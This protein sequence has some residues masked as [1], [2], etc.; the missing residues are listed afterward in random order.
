MPWISKR[1][2]KGWEFV[3]GLLGEGEEKGEGVLERDAV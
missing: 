2:R 1:W 3:M